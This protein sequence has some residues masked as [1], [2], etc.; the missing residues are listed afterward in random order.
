MAS[1]NGF[2][3]V[4]I[5]VSVAIGV[6]LAGLASFATV[7]FMKNQELDALA[8]TLVSYLRTAENRALQSEGNVGHGVSTAESKLTLF[9]GANYANK[10][11]SYDTTLSYPSYITFTGLNEVDFVKHTGAPS[12]TGTISVTNGIKTTVITVYSSGA[13]SKQ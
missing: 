3:M 9:R 1:R 10:Q 11:T 5:V 6:L 4:E 2:T 7:R 13:I 8:G 12:A